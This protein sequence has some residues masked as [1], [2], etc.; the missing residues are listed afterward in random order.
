MVGNIVESVTN[1]VMSGT[2]AIPLKLAVV[3]GRH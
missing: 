2:E 1:T 3:S